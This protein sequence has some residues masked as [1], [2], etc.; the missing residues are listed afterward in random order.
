MEIVS[1]KRSPMDLFNL[2]IF[3]SSPAKACGADTKLQR[4]K[5]GDFRLQSHKSGWC[6]FS[7]VGTCDRL[8]GRGYDAM[9][10]WP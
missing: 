8:A 3:P 5:H 1:I 2:T 7:Q 6:H 9:L 4:W 10:A